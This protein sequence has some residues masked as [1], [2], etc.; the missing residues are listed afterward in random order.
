MNN[1][2]YELVF[3]FLKV[4]S[5]HISLH[6]KT[7]V[8]YRDSHNTDTK[9]ETKVVN[10]SEIMHETSIL[11]CDKNYRVNIDVPFRVFYCS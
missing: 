5:Q 6:L 10:F 1:G 4:Y 9:T 3:V 8:V 11:F 7:G 2:V